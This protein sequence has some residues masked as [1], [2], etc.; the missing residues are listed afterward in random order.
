MEDAPEIFMLTL[1]AKTTTTDS[2]TLPEIA[3]DFKM[4]CVSVSGGLILLSSRLK[5][6]KQT[7]FSCYSN[8]F[9]CVVK[10]Q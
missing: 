4:K 1:R 2:N 9:C 8:K 7:F 3:G 10:H 6:I 5:K